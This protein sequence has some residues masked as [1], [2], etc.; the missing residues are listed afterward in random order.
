MSQQDARAADPGQLAGGV[1]HDFNNLLTVIGGYLGAGK[2]TLVN[3][4]LRAPGGRRI[5]VIVNDFGDIGIDA[6]LVV[7]RECG[8]GE[9]E[10]NKP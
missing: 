10:Q 7:G 9:R 8:R 3:R 1:A 4:L 5:G 2:T 6:D